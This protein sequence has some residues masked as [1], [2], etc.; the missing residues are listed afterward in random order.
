MSQ[1]LKIDCIMYRVRDLE[2]SAIFY[3]SLGMMRRWADDER[4]MIGFTFPESDSEIV[5]HTDNTVPNFD[6]CYQVANVEK[7][8]NEFRDRGYT[9]KLEPITVRTGK[10]AI[11]EDPDGNALP[12]ID[13]TLFGNVAQYDK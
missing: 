2:K 5:I 1:L 11:L 12:I 4:G 3:E 6:F 8:C 13:L 10:Y 7:L 9:I